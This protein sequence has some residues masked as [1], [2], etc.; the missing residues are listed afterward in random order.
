MDILPPQS[1]T[2]TTVL[3]TAVAEARRLGNSHVGVEH[4]L[5]GVIALDQNSKG[6]LNRLWRGKP[7]GSIVNMLPGLSARKLESIIQRQNVGFDHRVKGDPQWSAEA[8]YALRLADHERYWADQ[9][10]LEP[11]HI[12]LGVMRSAKGRTVLN[13]V[14]VTEWSVRLQDI[15]TA[16]FLAKDVPVRRQRS[17]YTASAKLAVSFAQDEAREHSHDEVDT[18]H[19]LIGLTRDRD[20]LAARVLRNLGADTERL[21]GRLLQMCPPQDRT[22]EVVGL[23]YTYKRLLDRA[24]NERYL[25]KHPRISTGHLLYHVALLDED[26]VALR[27][28]RRC[29]IRPRDVFATLE[30]YIQPQI[31]VLDGVASVDEINSPVLFTLT[32]EAQQ[33]FEVALEEAYRLEHYVLDTGHLLMGLL[34]DESGLTATLLAQNGVERRRV[35]ALLEVGNVHG[36]RYQLSTRRLHD[37]LQ[38]LV[39]QAIDVACVACHYAVVN[40]LHLLLALLKQSDTRAI[41]VLHELDVDIQHLQSSA[42]SHLKRTRS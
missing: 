26:D 23:S 10:T 1:H 31:A 22:V 2:A 41:W 8:Q 36:L 37:E 16:L 39:R 33:N 15:R 30:Q 21:R 40:P 42:M 34:M 4:L 29:E 17:R 13:V 25:R 9:R 20:G 19:L 12:L 5:L 28:L 6:L 7:S 27:V 14:G 38:A 3:D 11:E 35:R 18:G 24:A 32:F